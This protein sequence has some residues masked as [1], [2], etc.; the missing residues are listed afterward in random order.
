MDIFLLGKTA[1]LLKSQEAEKKQFLSPKPSSFNELAQKQTAVKQNIL[2]S[3]SVDGSSNTT[4][5]K[6]ITADAR[7]LIL[8]NYLEK[9]HSPLSDYADLIFKVSQKYG[10]DYRLIVAIAQQESNLCKKAP[11]NCFNCWG[12]GIHSR[13]T[14]CFNSFS[15][16]IEWMGKYLKEEYFDE[17]LSTVEEIM[18][19]YCPH[20]NGSW[21]FGVNQFISEMN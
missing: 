3:L 2:S 15:E 16:G 19:K 18:E 12:A 5:E 8:K 21:A 6:V 9:Y 10:F 7:P 11:E 14:M 4:E 17:G 1:V 13:G 20:S